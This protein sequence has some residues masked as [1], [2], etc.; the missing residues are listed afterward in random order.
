MRTVKRLII[1]LLGVAFSV[2]PACSPEL[3]SWAWTAVG[4]LLPLISGCLS[5]G[6]LSPTQTNPTQTQANNPATSQSASQTQTGSPVSVTIG[7]A[8]QAPHPRS[9]S[10]APP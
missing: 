6:S 7:D 5:P 8:F 9:S 2:I 1:V 10:P 3:K 4:S